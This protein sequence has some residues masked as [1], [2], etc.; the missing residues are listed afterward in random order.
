MMA[1]AV[2]RSNKIFNISKVIADVTLV[3]CAMFLFQL[4][5]H[6]K[7]IL[8]KDAR[9]IANQCSSVQL[10]TEVQM[11]NV[12]LLKNLYILFSMLCCKDTLV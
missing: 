7:T 6:F 9:S 12:F 2:T 11:L 3:M 4:L 10:N 1:E 8:N 5:H